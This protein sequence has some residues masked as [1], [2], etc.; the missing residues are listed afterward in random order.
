MSKAAYWRH[1]KQKRVYQGSYGFESKTKS[2]AFILI[3]TLKTGKEHAIAFES[4][5]A[6]KAAG[7]RKV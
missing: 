4:H 1:P 2:R 6:A 7:W 3:A 5:E